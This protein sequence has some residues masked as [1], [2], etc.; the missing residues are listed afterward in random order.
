MSKSN[1]AKNS[2]VTSNHVNVDQKPGNY[3]GQINTTKNPPPKP[4]SNIK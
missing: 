1:K 4:K 2:V 3:S